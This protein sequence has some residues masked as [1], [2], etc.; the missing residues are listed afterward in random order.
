MQSGAGPLPLIRAVVTTNAAYG[1]F[2]KRIDTGLL[3][4]MRFLLFGRSKRRLGCLATDLLNQP[5]G[6][7]P[8]FL[9][10]EL[11][12]VGALFCLLGGF[13]GYFESRLIS[14]NLNGELV[15]GRGGSIEHFPGISDPADCRRRFAT[16]FQLSGRFL[17]LLQGTKMFL[18]RLLDPLDFLS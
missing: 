5:G 8:D 12:E 4:P 9:L 14:C 18:L 1:F 17:E 3:G 13:E 16:A 15:D 10:F 2:G 7:T 11:F 6:T